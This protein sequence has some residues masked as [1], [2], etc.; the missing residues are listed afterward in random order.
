MSCYWYK[1]RVLERLEQ[2][3]FTN[4]WDWKLTINL[5][6]FCNINVQKG[7]LLVWEIVHTKPNAWFPAL[8]LR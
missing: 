5:G 6:A 8:R 2:N 3:T 1:I 4:P 7:F